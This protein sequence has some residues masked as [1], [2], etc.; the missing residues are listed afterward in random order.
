MQQIVV[1]TLATFF[2]HEG[3]AFFPLVALGIFFNFLLFFN[4]KSQTE[5][6]EQ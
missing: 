3:V 4:S 2:P 5:N 6:T 1:N